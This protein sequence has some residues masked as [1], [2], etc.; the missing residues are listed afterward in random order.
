MSI[1]VYKQF[2]SIKGTSGRLDKEELLQTYINDEFLFYLDFLLN[3]YIVTG[4]AAKKLNKKVNTKNFEGESVE[5][6]D[7]LKGLLNYLK[8]HNTGND[9]DIY[10]VQ[11]YLQK[12]T[13]D[14]YKTFI[15]ELITKSYKLGLSAKTVNRVFGTQT[16]PIFEVQLAHPYEKQEHRVTGE[17]FI[18]TKLDGNRLLILIDE[19]GGIT[20]RTRTG[21]DVVELPEITDKVKALNLKNTVIDG[22]VLITD[23]S[24]SK[25]DAFNETMKIIRR[26]GVKTG[27]TY[28]AFDILTY[29]EF[30]QGL[31]KQNYQQRRLELDKLPVNDQFRVVPLLYQG[32]DKGV[33]PEILKTVLLAGEEGL[34]IN[35]NESYRCKRTHTLLKVKEFYTDD[36]LVV[37]LQEGTGKYQGMMGGVEVDY[38]GNRVLVG[39][40]FN[41][42]ERELYFN[43]PELIVGKIIE[44]QYFSESKNQKDD[45]VSLRFPTFK[46]LREDK[47]EVNIE[48]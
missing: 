27:L 20:Y 35:L 42:E 16:I 10:T 3:D 37:G 11:Q 9:T 24:V 29:D 8:V 18:T 32:N 17:F 1:T 45:K 28:H 39:S 25:E 33:I 5:D 41:D 6:F 15:K 7:D 48:S 43:Q 47:D 40:G 34:M 13:D 26:D 31:S 38:K 44:V 19:L 30:R 36:L 12:V 14:G 22:E 23:T 2:E 21:K 46:G 4:L